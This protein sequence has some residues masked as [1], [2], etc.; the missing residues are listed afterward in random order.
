MRKTL[1]ILA[2]I[3]GLVAALGGLAIEAVLATLY[4]LG[5]EAIRAEPAVS[6]ALAL[7]VAMIGVGL[8]LLLAWAGWQALRGV[9]G[10]TFSLPR[11]GWFL[12]GLAVVLGLGQVALARDVA[13][14]AALSHVLAAALGVCLALAWILG[15]ARRG[16]GV[17][18][19]PMIGSLAWGGLGAV[20]I[21]FAA[22]AIVML[23]AV[24]GA[25]V[26]LV[27]ARPDFL[28]HLKEWMAI[29]PGEMPDPGALTPLVRSPW[30]WLAAFG[31]ACVLVPL[32]EEAAKSLA[33][34]L[35]V[36]SGQRPAALDGFLFGAAAG[37]G[38]ALFESAANGA[39]ALGQ[40]SGWSALML[41]RLGATGMH[42]LA[43]GLTGLAWQQGLVEDRWVRA[44]GL[45][46]L[47]VVLHGAWNL[48]ALGITVIGLGTATSGEGIAQI[49]GLIALALAGVL[50]MLVVGIFI[51]LSVIP[52]R[53]ARASRPAMSMLEIT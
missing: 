11:W 23:I 35:I 15:A 9:P 27:V 5:R 17:A 37:A 8:G 39:L 2:V 52:R 51:A 25:G 32:I 34:P 16:S 1:L 6:G 31:G 7:T 40:G 46:L 18:A 19:R 26:Y 3:G 12:L 14:L 42:I 4:W 44:G 41:V 20:G 28:Q 29:R 24:A 30:V 47:A 50:M 49:G 13:W 21:A 10:G 48:F 36:V 38:F 33:V 22:E 53:L 45:G 43:S